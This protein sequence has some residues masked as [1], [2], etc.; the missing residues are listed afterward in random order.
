MLAALVALSP[1]SAGWQSVFYGLGLLIAI[2]AAFSVDRWT[3][4]NLLALAFAC[5]VFVFF[6]NALAATD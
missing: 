6:V 1:L 5:F 4:I 2:V 3:K